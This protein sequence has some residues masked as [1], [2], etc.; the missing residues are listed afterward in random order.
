M[1]VGE[2]SAVGDRLV[3][4]ALEEPLA[5]EQ[6]VDGG[7]REVDVGGN[8]L[9]PCFADHGAHGERGVG[10]LHGDQRF[11]D[12]GGQPAGTAAVGAW[13]GMQG[14]EAAAAVEAQ[15]VA[16]GL[17]GDA[18][19][20]GAGD[21]VVAFGLGAQPGADAR[22]AG[23]QVDEVGD[24]AV[25]E[26]RH[27]LP[28]VVVGGLRHVAGLVRRRGG[29]AQPGERRVGAETGAECGDRGGAA[30]EAL[31]EQAAHGIEGAPN[32][33]DP[34][35]QP[36]HGASGFRAPTAQRGG[37]RRH[38]ARVLGGRHGI[39]EFGERARRPPPDSP[40]AG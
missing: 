21:V 12:L 11:G 14:V 6:A 19:A 5:G 2:A 37:G 38:A 28:E 34:P 22:G 25:A 17:G 39:L 33:T 8:V 1:A 27:G 26:Q 36:A 7:R 29:L 23:W 40:A 30:E 3:G 24:E 9:P 35:P 16:E 20:V 31:R 10:R 32:Q 13:P 18:G 4:V 15:P